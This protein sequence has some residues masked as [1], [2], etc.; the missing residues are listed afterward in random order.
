[1]SILRYYLATSRE[2]KRLDA[3]SRS[4]IF[5]WFS[6]SIAGLSTIRAFGQ[7]DIFQ[8]SNHRNVDRNQ[9]CY[10]SSVSGNRWLSLRLEFLGAII[11]FLVATLA[12]VALITTGI[13][14]GL[15]GLVLSYALNSTSSLVRMYCDLD[16]KLTKLTFLQNWVIRSASEVEQNIVSVERILHQIEEKPEAPLKLEHSKTPESW[17]AEGAIDFKLV[18]SW[19]MRNTN[20]C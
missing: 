6:E 16:R 17:P 11:I 10:L 13:D 1:M 3:V 19:F 18:M 9:L 7:Q 14:A 8:A 12:M 15:V 5:A 4:P 20:L 2:L